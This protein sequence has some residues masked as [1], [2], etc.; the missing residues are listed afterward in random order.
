MG[1]GRKEINMKQKQQQDKIK[2]NGVCVGLTILLLSASSSIVCDR[3][4][5]IREMCCQD[6]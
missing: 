3:G 4:P 1:T 5:N 6:P 2:E